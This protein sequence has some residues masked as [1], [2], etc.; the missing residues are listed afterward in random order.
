MDT[1]T[2]SP[3]ASYIADDAPWSAYPPVVLREQCLQRTLSPVGDANEL[4]F[5]LD[6]YYQRHK[7]E[8]RA[9]FPWR[10]AKDIA[11]TRAETEARAKTFR[12][13]RVLDRSCLGTSRIESHFNLV[14][15][16][17][18][19]MTDY[20]N[21]TIGR[22]PTCNCA[23]KNTKT[24]AGYSNWTCP[25]IIYVLK[26]ILGC[27]NPLR[28]QAAFL[29][30]ELVK[31]Y[32]YSTVF[33]LIDCH[34]L[35][36]PRGSRPREPKVRLHDLPYHDIYPTHI[37][38]ICFRFI[39]VGQTTRPCSSC[40]LP[41]HRSCGTLK[42]AWRTYLDIVSGA[43][44]GYVEAQYRAKMEKAIAEAME[45]T[46]D[47]D[48]EM[49]DVCDTDFW[50]EG[51][52]LEMEDSSDSEDYDDDDDQQAVDGFNKQEDN[53]DQASTATGIATANVTSDGQR[54]M[55]LCIRLGRG[56][57]DQE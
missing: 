14:G 53:A 1:T 5:R 31:I 24:D 48:V 9:H 40:G 30:D 28:F 21:I 43:A 54:E 12:V 46:E 7:R 41:V 36:L 56:M 39:R 16:S 15:G 38:M 33:E 37:C 17:G 2:D 13:L 25:H 47:Q 23:F 55:T 8:E 29:F 34:G 18:K 51:N 52:E 4:R 22:N 19:Y 20:F 6:D 10:V 3:L 27:P 35:H 49:E 26:Y 50:L 42:S 44:D 45:D 57:N 32:R 11:Y